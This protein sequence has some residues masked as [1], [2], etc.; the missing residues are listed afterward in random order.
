MYGAV[1]ARL[2]AGTHQTEAAATLLHELTHRDLSDWHVDE[3]WLASICLLAETCAILDD[4]ESAG[5]LYELLMPYGSQNAVALVELALDS[6]SRSLGILAT[7]Q[8]RFE[9]AARHFQ[10]A[11]RMNERMGARPWVAHTQEDLA[12]ML[13]RRNANGDREHADELLSRAQATYHELGMQGDAAQAAALSA[14]G[15]HG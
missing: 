8:G 2:Y 14:T 15:A 10:E 9:D 3:E 6:V 5:S 7:L 13:L 11:L 12:R 1:L 4:A